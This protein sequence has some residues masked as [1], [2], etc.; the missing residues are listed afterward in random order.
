MVY[1]DCIIENKYDIHLIAL[2]IFSLAFLQRLKNP[3]L[4]TG[5]TFYF[6]RITVDIKER[7][8]W[9][10][11]FMTPV[12]LYS[13]LSHFSR[14]FFTIHSS[15][16]RLL[17][18]KGGWETLQSE[19]FYALMVCHSHHGL[20]SIP[21]ILTSSLTQQCVYS[22]APHRTTPDLTPLKKHMFTTC[23]DET[24]TKN[25]LGIKMN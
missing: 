8:F 21:G 11:D 19:P 14:L 9:Y 10:C 5:L 3:C 6:Q 2:K 15:F 20:E 1:C 7:Q 4:M 24:H 17:K 13:S 23:S 12:V 25:F 22:N 18:P 16:S